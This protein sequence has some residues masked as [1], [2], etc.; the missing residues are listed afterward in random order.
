MTKLND[1][2][3]IPQIGF[4][5]F[6]IP[7]WAETEKAVAFALSRGCR[8][9]DTAAAYFNEADVGNAVRASGVKRNEVFVTSKLWLQD[10]GY[11]AAKDL[12]RGQSPYFRRPARVK[13]QGLKP[14]ANAGDVGFRRKSWAAAFTNCG[15]A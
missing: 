13:S 10:Y 1:G 5:T 6:Q 3:A 8:H 9:I 11:E 14:S 12:H 4:G 7:A 15:S 2:V